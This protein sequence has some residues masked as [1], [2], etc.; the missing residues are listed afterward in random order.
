MGQEKEAK[1]PLGHIK[2]HALNQP[3]KFKLEI[4]HLS[5]EKIYLSIFLEPWKNN[6][7]LQER[8]HKYP[9]IPYI[10]FWDL[11][12]NYVSAKATS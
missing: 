3:A 11:L 10:A 6:N 12:E 7:I 9:T 1:T 2:I 8:R 5:P 4:S